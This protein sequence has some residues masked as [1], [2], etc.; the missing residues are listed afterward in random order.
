[1]EKQWEIVRACWS[2]T[3]SVSFRAEDC[4]ETDLLCL[5]TISIVVTAEA[6]VHSI[7]QDDAARSMLWRQVERTLIRSKAVPAALYLSS[8]LD[9]TLFGAKVVNRT[10]GNPRGLREIDQRGPRWELELKHEVL[11]MA[12][13]MGIERESK[14]KRVSTLYQN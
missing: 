10:L 5:S 9:K 6:E 14:I 3:A 11:C 13:G 2:I 12:I 4:I 8:V 7:P 1:V